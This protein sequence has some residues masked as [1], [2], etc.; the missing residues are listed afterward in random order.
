MTLRCPRCGRG[1]PAYQNRKR[2]KKQVR[3]SDLCT[4]CQNADLID[5]LKPAKRSV[6]TIN[7]LSELPRA[8]RER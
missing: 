3:S 8:W 1:S 4:D 5:Q 7:S 2:A 6:R